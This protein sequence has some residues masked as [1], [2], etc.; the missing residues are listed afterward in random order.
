MSLD[1]QTCASS[2]PMIFADHS[3]YVCP[4][5]GIISHFKCQQYWDQS[6]SL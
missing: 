3:A 2:D 1:I 4:R 6:S 5:T